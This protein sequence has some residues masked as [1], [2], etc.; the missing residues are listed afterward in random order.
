MR[1]CNHR[2]RRRML[3]VLNNLT[4]SNM[5]IS[6]R[7]QI[8]PR[9]IVSIS[10]HVVTSAKKMFPGWRA[11]VNLNVFQA[12]FFRVAPHDFTR[13]YSISRKFIGNLHDLFENKR[14]T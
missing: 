1:R 10:G 14:Q 4:S 2:H 7:N 11:V 12:R 3:I 8:E 6:A 13:I 5:K 9:K